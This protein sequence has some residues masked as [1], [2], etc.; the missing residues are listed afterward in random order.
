MRFRRL[1]ALR[2]PETTGTI[3]IE[4]AFAD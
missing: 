4:K 1:S 2:A 3:L